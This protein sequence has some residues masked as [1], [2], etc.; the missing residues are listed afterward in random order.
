M[1]DCLIFISRSLVPKDIVLSIAPQQHHSLQKRPESVESWEWLW[2]FWRCGTCDSYVTCTPLPSLAL[3]Y[4]SLKS[5][6]WPNWQALNFQIEKVTCEDRGWVPASL[7]QSLIWGLSLYFWDPLIKGY[8]WC[9][10]WQ[11]P[12]NQTHPIMG[13]SLASRVI[14]QVKSYH[15]HTTRPLGRLGFLSIWLIVAIF[16]SLGDFWSAGSSPATAF[17]HQ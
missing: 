6:N 7:N 2:R 10:Y 16:L 12:K 5:C 4:P 17:L 15:P 14:V 9:I 11:Q 8:T 1:C 3:P 13:A